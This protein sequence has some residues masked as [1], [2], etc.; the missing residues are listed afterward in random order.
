M[1]RY[2]IKRPAHESGALP[3]RPVTRGLLHAHSLAEAAGF[4][5]GTHDGWTYAII[6]SGAARATLA[7][8]VAADERGEVGEVVLVAPGGV[9]GHTVPASRAIGALHLGEP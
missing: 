6:G 9:I 4:C 2:Y 1:T 7:D 3:S 8:A 5:L